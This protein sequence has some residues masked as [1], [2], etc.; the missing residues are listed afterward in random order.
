MKGLVSQ[1]TRRTWRSPV[2]VERQLLFTYLRTSPLHTTVT[3]VMK[4]PAHS[5]LCMFRIRYNLEPE[6]RTEANHDCSSCWGKE[7][8]SSEIR[9]LRGFNVRL[10]RTY[11]WWIQYEA[12]HWSVIINLQLTSDSSVGAYLSSYGSVMHW[13]W[14][15]TDLRYIKIWC[16]METNIR[17]C[18]KLLSVSCNIHWILGMD[19]PG[20][21]ILQQTVHICMWNSP[22]R[23]TWALLFPAMFLFRATCE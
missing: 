16:W 9:G 15:T 23:Y 6:Q 2:G 4:P 12:L 22:R 10:I 5:S 13:M 14:L 3:A 7:W 21:D 1:N 8:H 20:D 17:V 18:D 19:R 11:V